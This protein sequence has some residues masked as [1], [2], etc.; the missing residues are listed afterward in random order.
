MAFLNEKV[1]QDIAAAFKDLRDGVVLKFFTQEMECRFCRETRGL[2]EE[3]VALEPRI[4][5]QVLDLV[6][7]AGAAAELGIARIPAVAV[8]DD[9]DYGIRFYGIPA[10]YEFA[11]LVEA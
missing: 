4:K 10:G 7:D 6:G 3:L 5:L 11:S 2:L 8:Q 1:R 9:K